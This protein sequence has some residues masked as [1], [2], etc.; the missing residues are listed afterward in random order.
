MI[1]D[2]EEEEEGA[3]A[4]ST[5]RRRY[6]TVTGESEPEDDSDEYRSLESKDGAF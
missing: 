6:I 5:Q 2:D 4:G 1:L 3:F